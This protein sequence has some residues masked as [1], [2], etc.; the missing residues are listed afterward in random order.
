[1]SAGLPVLLAGI[2]GATLAVAVRELSLDLPW[3]RRYLGS[4]LGALG[5]SGSEGSPPDPVEQRRLG[6]LAGIVLG[7][8]ALL[9]LGPGPPALLAALGPAGATRVVT[10]RRRRYRRRLESQIPSLARGIADALGSGGSLRT[11]LVD[12]AAVIDGPAGV[13]LARV[14]ADLSL[15][16]PPREALRALAQRS[17]S[18]PVGRLVAAIVSQQ[19]SGGDL[20]GL[21]RTHAE[22]AIKRQRAEKEARSAT[23][24]ARLTGGMVVAMPV[25]AALL[26]ELASP[27]FL[28][29]MLAE[30]LA[31]VLLLV[32]LGLQ[33]GGYLLIQRLG[34]VR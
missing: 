11:A 4:A 12:L 25:G 9:L 14:R 21:L 27:G 16:V 34:R 19:R 17:N 10:G 31:L 18:E 2:G 13:E 7:G 5:R 22:A 28:G 33:L 20:A 1:M 6:V 30:P 29:S 24:Q 23:A 8:L 3:L 15:G 32:A 26:V